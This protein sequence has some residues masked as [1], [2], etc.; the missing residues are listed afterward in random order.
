MKKVITK[1]GPGEISA[2]TIGKQGEVTGYLVQFT[3]SDLT[4]EQ[5]AAVNLHGPFGFKVVSMA[6]VI[7]IEEAARCVK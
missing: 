6:D 2:Q 7:Q 4:A 5:L 1:F 3:A